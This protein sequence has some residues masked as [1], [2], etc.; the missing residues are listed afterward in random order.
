MADLPTITM[1]YDPARGHR[2]N[3]DGCLD[4]GEWMAVESAAIAAGLAHQCADEG[5]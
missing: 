5:K 2:W 4:F 3:C 1:E